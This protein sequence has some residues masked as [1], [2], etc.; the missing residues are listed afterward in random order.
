VCST[1]HECRAHNENLT[2]CNR[3]PGLARKRNGM[4]LHVWLAYAAQV[5]QPGREVERELILRDNGQ[6]LSLGLVV[7]QKP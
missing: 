2:T 7:G 4:L 3:T 6:W 5:T 1:R